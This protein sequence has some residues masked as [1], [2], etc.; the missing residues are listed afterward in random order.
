MPLTAM[1]DFQDVDSSIT[2]HTGS[3]LEHSYDGV[4]SAP[5]EV[6]KHLVR[7]RSG[8]ISHSIAMLSVVRR[9]WK[10]APCVPDTVR[11]Q[12]I[13]ARRPCQSVAP[14]THSPHMPS[15]APAMPQLVKQRSRVHIH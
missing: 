7:H 13:L 3:A 11:W 10:A 9:P 5:I 15:T 8:C 1:W 4:N 12:P 6:L 14:N 2:S